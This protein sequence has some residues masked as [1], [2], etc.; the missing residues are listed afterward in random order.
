[1][2]MKESPIASHV[3]PCADWSTRVYMYAS[4]NK[5][6]RSLKFLI[7]FVVCLLKKMTD[8]Q[9]ITVNDGD[10]SA[11]VVL[12]EGDGRPLSRRYDADRPLAVP[13]VEVN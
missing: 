1:M 10:V 2:I 6:M 9:K 5:S 8:V 3:H 7:F 12:R 4:P 13:T 11:L